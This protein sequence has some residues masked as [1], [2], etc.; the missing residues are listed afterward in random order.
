MDNDDVRHEFDH[1]FSLV[2]EQMGELSV[3]Q[4][5]QMALT[6]TGTAAE[7]LVEVSVDARRMVTKTVIDESY[8]DEFEF[9]DLSGYVTAA[10]QSAAEKLEQRSAALLAPLNERRQRISSLAGRVGDAPDFAE[11][12][13]GL[14]SVVADKQRDGGDGMEEHSTFPI[15]RS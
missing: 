5:K 6:A 12:L 11:L 9:A 8:L 10:A 14:N 7:G 1:V 15:V 2:Q 4:Q 13:A 3:M